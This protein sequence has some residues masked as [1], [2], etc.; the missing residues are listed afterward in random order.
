[1]LDLYVYEAIGLAN[2]AG[3]DRTGGFAISTLGFD[4]KSRPA[5]D[6]EGVVVA[7]NEIR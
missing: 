3:V 1:M 5:V 4:P 6:E 2:E 7:R